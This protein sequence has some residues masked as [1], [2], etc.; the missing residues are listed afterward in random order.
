MKKILIVLFLIF[1]SNS[2]LSALDS[3]YYELNAKVDDN[4][5]KCRLQSVIKYLKND[6][7]FLGF[8]KKFNKKS[9]FEFTGGVYSN[10]IFQE[11]FKY[12]FPSATKKELFYIWKDFFKNTVPKIDTTYRYLNK[13]LN[14]KCKDKYDLGF[15]IINKNL[16]TYSIFKDYKS[17]NRDGMF[18]T[19]QFNDDC[20]ILRVINYNIMQ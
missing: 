13:S 6:P 7:T 14:I 4:I 15:G 9:C 19:I 10:Y 11:D 1:I 16:I 20:E 8:F 3:L 18:Y 2:R 12:Y 17:G 5:L